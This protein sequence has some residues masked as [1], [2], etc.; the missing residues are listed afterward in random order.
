[1]KRMKSRMRMNQSNRKKIPQS[2]HQKRKLRQTSEPLSKRRRRAKRRKIKEI[3]IRKKAKINRR[4]SDV[5]PIILH[6]NYL[7]KFERKLL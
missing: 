4:L 6:H 5:Y 3:R 1:M 7:S 2:K